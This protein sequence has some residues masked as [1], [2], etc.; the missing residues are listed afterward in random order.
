MQTQ[1][2]TLRKRIEIFA[3]QKDKYILPA[4]AIIIVATMLIF[5]VLF[6]L[7]M[8]FH[9]WS[10]GVKPPEF[11]GIQNYLDLFEDKRFFSSLLRTGYFVILS[12]GS[13]LVLGL[14]AAIVFHRSFI[15]RGVARAFFLF[16]MIATPSAMALVWK[17][18]LD[19]TIGVLA[20][21]VEG[22]G[23][24]PPTFTADASTVIP[25]LVMVDTWQWTP[26]IMLIMLAGLAALPLEPFEAA[27]VDGAS[28]LQMFYYITLPL[29]RPTFA[30]AAMFR[31]IDCIKTF[32]IIMVITGGGPGYSSEILNIYAF[33]ESLTYFHFGYGSTLLVAL[34]LIVFCVAVFFNRIRRVG[35]WV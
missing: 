21:L 8:S 6:T 12:V 7:Y 32:D 10:G 24:P 29:L 27:Q 1:E 14:L 22:L 18:L 30:V 4:P 15:G 13:Q 9:E 11:V 31:M 5:P 20:H 34:A 28:P 2:I 23:L 35:Y 25:T 17:M 33:T 19:P 26:L 16:P 3:D